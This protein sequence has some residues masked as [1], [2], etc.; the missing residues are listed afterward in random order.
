MNKPTLTGCLIGSCLLL[1]SAELSGQG[2]QADFDRANGLA[3]QTRNQ[4]FR[5]KVPWNVIPGS[6]SFW[7]DVATGTRTHEFVLVDS[8]EYD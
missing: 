6:E 8:P 3:A 2:T 7:Y 5:N 4:V 1:L